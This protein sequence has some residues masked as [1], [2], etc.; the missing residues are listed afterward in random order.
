MG[1]DDVTAEDLVGADAAVVAALRCREA[2]DG[3]AEGRP[4][5]KKVY[6]CSMPKIGSWSANFSAIG[7]QAAPGVR[8]V[9]LMSM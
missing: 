2:A 8:H 4:S 5:L 1:L 3:E 9:G 6:S 7:A